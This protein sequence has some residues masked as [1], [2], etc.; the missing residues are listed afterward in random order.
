MNDS[1]VTE[2]KTCR[3]CGGNALVPLL[4][5]GN[6]V[7]TGRFPKPDDPPPPNGP[8]GLVICSTG[9]EKNGCGLVQLSHIFAPQEMYGQ[10][11]AYASSVTATMREHLAEIAGYVTGWAR[12]QSGDAVLDIGCNDGTLLRHFSSNSV[13][14]T[15]IDPSGDCVGL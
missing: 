13:L 6:Q 8:L 7:F 1:F 15:G 14:L 3:A 9:K 11:Y 2:L 12:F 10:T 4:D 5:L